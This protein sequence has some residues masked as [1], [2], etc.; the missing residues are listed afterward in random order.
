MGFLRGTGVRGGLKEVNGHI[1]VVS[2]KYPITGETCLV[3]VSPF[4]CSSSS[5]FA[6]MFLE[7]TYSWGRADSAARV[8]QGWRE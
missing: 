2:P 6:V 1:T 8:E 7:T 3:E 4:L 5:F